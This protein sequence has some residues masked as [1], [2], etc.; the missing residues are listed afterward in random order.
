MKEAKEKVCMN[1]SCLGAMGLKR[2]DRPRVLL[3]KN[4]WNCK[5][6]VYLVEIE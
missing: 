4:C 6:S 1:P 5:Q 2:D 3:G